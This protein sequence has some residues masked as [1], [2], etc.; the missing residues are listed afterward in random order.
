MVSGVAGDTITL[1]YRVQK[2]NFLRLD[3]FY[4]GVKS[5]AVYKDKTYSQKQ[6]PS[7]LDFTDT[8]SSYSHVKPVYSFEFRILKLNSSLHQGGILKHQVFYNVGG[9]EYNTDVDTTL[10]V[11]HKPKIIGK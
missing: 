9:I 3:L 7:F 2:S 6:K 11:L 10:N 5:L 4:N 1:K 8:E